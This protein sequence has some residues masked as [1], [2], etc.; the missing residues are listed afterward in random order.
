M[1]E[2]VHRSG[3]NRYPSSALAEPEYDPFGKFYAESLS[4]VPSSQ[5]RIKKSKVE[6][7]GNAMKVKIYIAEYSFN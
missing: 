7:E 5:A 3:G 6:K 1:A 2:T 4:S